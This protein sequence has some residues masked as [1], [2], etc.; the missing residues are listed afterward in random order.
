MACYD[1]N[2][3]FIKAISLP[4]KQVTCPCFGGPDL[5]TLYVTSASEGLSAKE[6]QEQPLAGAVF[7]VQLEVEGRPERRLSFD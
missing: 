5:K 2:G 1:P 6:H 7:A 4:A 3:R